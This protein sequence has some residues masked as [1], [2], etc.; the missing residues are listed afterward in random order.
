ME[1]S[2][3]KNAK[4]IIFQGQRMF[5]ADILRSES[6]A[7]DETS[8]AALQEI[9]KTLEHDK[10]RIHIERKFLP[11]N[12]VKAEGMEKSFSHEELLNS[13]KGKK[14]IWLIDD[15][16]KGKTTEFRLLAKEM[17]QKY[18]KH[19][20]VFLNLI[21][22]VEA[23]ADPISF[24]SSVDLAK[25][26]CEKI[27]KI[28]AVE[29]QI[30]MNLFNDGRVIIMMDAF[31]EIN[32][33]IQENVEKI[34]IENNA[35]QIWISTRPK[36]EGKNLK[37]DCFKLRLFTFEDQDKF[38]KAL[39]KNEAD[40]NNKEKIREISFFLSGL[41]SYRSNQVNNPIIFRLLIEVF[42]E[43]DIELKD[44][45]Y[46]QLYK[47]FVDIMISKSLV[48]HQFSSED[49]FAFHQ[50]LG[51]ISV[52]G[53]DMEGSKKIIE[54]HFQNLPQAQEM[55]KVGLI[56]INGSEEIR[57]LDLTLS[58]FFAADFFYKNIFLNDDKSF[59]E[60]FR[61]IWN[62]KASYG[63]RMITKFLNSIFESLNTDE[64][65]KIQATFVR[66]MPEPELQE[67]FRLAVFDDCLNLIRI[68]SLIFKNMQDTLFEM[69]SVRR[70]GTN[71]L[72]MAVEGR[73]T[74]YIDRTLRIAHEVL[75]TLR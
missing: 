3:N 53:M 29:A 9:G 58:E 12:Q 27:L 39:I 63:C 50:K 72:M 34:F 65:Q 75:S 2:I 37:S 42:E 61:F 43:K 45:N 16:G 52:F 32:S 60:M 69:W 5:L 24:E 1:S 20:L 68:I 46:Y 70:F 7:V 30:F 49:I 71:A 35:N 64:L 4:E 21:D 22:H 41:N 6:S 15:H 10:L 55:T 14:I 59:I 48:K 66:L 17:K 56:S 67:V 74:N 11:L 18:P 25:F 38:I 8:M 73:S 47:S 57:F 54:N 44:K 51:L 36:A 31:D 62:V 23:F 26:F 28:D 40:V 19:W 33:K 13:V